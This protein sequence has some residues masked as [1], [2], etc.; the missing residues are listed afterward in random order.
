MSERS[1]RD[2]T[3]RCSARSGDALNGA[4]C[5]L[6]TFATQIETFATQIDWSM[7]Q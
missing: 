7:H 6:A 2:V 4:P 5:A 3:V 1:E